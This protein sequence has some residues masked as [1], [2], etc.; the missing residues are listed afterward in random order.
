MRNPHLLVKL[1]FKKPES[2]ISAIIISGIDKSNHC[3]ET[4]IDM[5][6]QRERVGN[7]AK[8]TGHSVLVGLSKRVV[9]VRLADNTSPTD[10]VPTRLTHDGTGHLI[11]IAAKNFVTPATTESLLQLKSVNG[12]F[13]R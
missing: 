4:V 9:F 1:L 10:A 7:V 6:F 13:G 11:G 2:M 12:T 5:E 8:W 3:T